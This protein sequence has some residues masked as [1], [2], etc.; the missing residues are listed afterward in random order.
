MLALGGAAQI[1]GA[2]QPNDY[3]PA[4]YEDPNA[5]ALTRGPV[6]EAFCRNS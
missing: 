1:T 5:Q 2:Q 4:N 6:H 3:Q